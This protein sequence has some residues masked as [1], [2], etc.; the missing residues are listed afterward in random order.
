MYVA[1]PAHGSQ[2]SQPFEHAGKLLTL[3]RERLLSLRRFGL[4]RPFEQLCRSALSR[5]QSGHF[6]LI[7]W[8]LGPLE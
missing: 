2:V 6:V 8:W 3:L 1:Q 4:A 5:F 7:Q